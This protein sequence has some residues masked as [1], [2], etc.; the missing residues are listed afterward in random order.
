MLKVA[1]IINP[2]KV[3]S[4]SDLHISQPITF[5]SLRIAKDFSKREVDVDLITA[6]FPEDHEIIPDYF[7]KTEDLYRS[8]LDVSDFEVQRK[9]P[10][11]VDIINCAYRMTDVNDYIIYSNVDIAV[12]PHF[13][14]FVKKQIELGHDAL[15]INR[16]TISG[17]YSTVDEMPL[18]YAEI[19]DTHPGYD[20]FVFKGDIISKMVLENIC[21]GAA[22]IGLAMY[23]NLRLLSS[24]FKEFG[25]EHITFHIGNEKRW[26]KKENDQYKIHNKKEF[27][28]VKDKLSFKFEGVQTII[29]GA[30]PNL[31]PGGLEYTEN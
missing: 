18:M 11:I 24:N 23:L 15:V 2:V 14:S 21:V 19:G 5:E 22:Y 27:Q 30:F 20:C 25:N 8:I 4:S 7:H 12:Q 26:K 31:N 29:K 16:R 17:K 6:Q 1:H 28:K 13:Y 9:L 3:G 10:L